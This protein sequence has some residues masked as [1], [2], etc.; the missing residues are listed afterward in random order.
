[1]DSVFPVLL[2]LVTSLSGQ[3]VGRQGLLATSLL[4]FVAQ[5]PGQPFAA[6][7]L[8]NQNCQLCRYAQKTSLENVPEPQTDLEY[9]ESKMKI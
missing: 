1:M 2:S 9:K 8:E 4:C 3:G 6:W 5:G 7:A